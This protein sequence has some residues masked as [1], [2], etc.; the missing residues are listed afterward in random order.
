VH[1]KGTRH[2]RVTLVERLCD[3]ALIGEGT[4]DRRLRGRL[5][6]H[7]HIVSPALSPP[8]YFFK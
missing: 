5:Q 2:R 7:A 8:R 4:A 3:D 1:K 6:K